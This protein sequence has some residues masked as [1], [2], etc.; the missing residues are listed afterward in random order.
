MA[1]TD[2]EWTVRLEDPAA[3]ADLWGALEDPDPSP[4][5][6]LSYIR[7]VEVDRFNGFRVEVFAREH[8]PPHF[9]VRYQGETAT[10]RLSDGERL[11]G[12]LKVH[13]RKIRDWYRRNRSTV[14][15]AWNKHRPTDCP[16]GVVRGDA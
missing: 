1:A 6:E 14:I 3:L 12:A 8:P 2:L 5:P 11:H 7:K 16:V 13:T 10:F 9:R 4:P 15:D